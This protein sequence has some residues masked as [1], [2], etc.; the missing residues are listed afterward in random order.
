MDAF[1]SQII[2]VLLDILPPNVIGSYIFEIDSIVQVRIRG[3][4]ARRPGPPLALGFEAAKL[5]I[6]G[7]YLIFP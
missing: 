7:P 4:G 2:N 5:S 1:S 3:R 6:F